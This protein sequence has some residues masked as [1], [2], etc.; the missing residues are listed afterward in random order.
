M[1][2]TR[3][4]MILAMVWAGLSAH[5]WTDDHQ[6]LS[7][8]LGEDA[9]P[10]GEA[11]GVVGVRYLDTE[12][13]E[14]G[15]DD[16]GAK[17]FV[18]RGAFETTA[19]PHHWLELNFEFRLSQALPLL[20][21]GQS[22]LMKRWNDLFTPDAPRPVRWTDCRRDVDF[23]E[24]QAATNLPKGKSFVIWVMAVVRDYAR[25]TLV[26]SGWDVRQPLL[27]ETD[28]NGSIVDM[29]TVRLDTNH[30]MDI[31]SEGERLMVREMQ[32]QTEF[33]SK[34]KGLLA[35]EAI[36]QKG[37]PVRILM[38]GTKQLWDPMDFGYA[39]SPIETPEAAR[40]L[41]E[42]LHPGATVLET[43][44]QYDAVVGAVR[45]AGERLRQ[46]LRE[47]PSIA[48]AVVSPVEGLGYKVR[49]LLLEPG[50]K[51][52]SIGNVT[53]WTYY[54]TRDGRLGEERTVCIRGPQAAGPQP[55]GW[56]RITPAD[57]EIYSEAIRAVLEEDQTRRIADPFRS[58]GRNVAIH[59]PAS[60]DRSVF[61]VPTEEESEPPQSAPDET[62]AE[63]AA[64]D[65]SSSE[66][67]RVD[68]PATPAPPQDAPTPDRNAEAETPAE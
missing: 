38:V 17:F 31:D 46:S 65:T 35:Y 2:T 59:A 21:E 28:D 56:T 41:V 54:V 52:G 19:P 27:V 61:Q 30:P 18:V 40:E 32:L 1:T 64:E 47:D 58:T 63:S 22:P 16:A 14:I 10:D 24:L 13:T 34:P 43:R 60:V 45:S 7:E 53:Q 20:V 4:I 12:V 5:G 29:Q 44:E 26:G 33:L 57:A 68:E 9:N 15:Q 62:P 6:T 66:P 55:E 8:T 48:G 50:P 37:N 49:L 23:A 51:D 42:L 11:A 36:D 3:W 67:V 39:L 25:G